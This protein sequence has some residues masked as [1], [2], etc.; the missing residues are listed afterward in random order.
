MTTLWLFSFSANRF[1][2]FNFAPPPPRPKNLPPVLRSAFGDRHNAGSLDTKCFFFNL[3]GAVV[4]SHLNHAGCKKK[5]GGKFSKLQTEDRKRKGTLSGTLVTSFRKSIRHIG[6]WPGGQ[7]T[8][9]PPYISPP[10]RTVRACSAGE[11]TPPLNYWLLPDWPPAKANF[12]C[13]FSRSSF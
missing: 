9:Q 10:R 12:S 7:R 8:G 2:M 11:W 3:L 6:L 4:V 13:R 1:L 5:G